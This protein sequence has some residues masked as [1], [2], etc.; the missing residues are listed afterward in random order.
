[1]L[2]AEY[3]KTV[4]EIFVSLC[5][6]FSSKVSLLEDEFDQTVVQLLGEVANFEVQQIFCGLVVLCG[7]LY[8]YDLSSE[9]S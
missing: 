6:P 2:L 4:A 5:I 9:V 1:M 7:M 8:I 3:V